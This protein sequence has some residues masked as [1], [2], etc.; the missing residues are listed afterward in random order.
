M[1]IIPIKE[2]EAIV[3]KSDTMVFCTCAETNQAQYLE[4]VKAW[5]AYVHE[6]VNADL[7]V[8][9]DGKLLSNNQRVDLG[10][11]T[12]VEFPMVAG[13][14]SI[15][16]FPG[17]KRSFAGA[18]LIS[19]HYKYFGHIEND[20]FVKDI[21]R[22]DKYL[23]TDNTVA[24][25]WCSNHNF[26]E[27][28]AAVIN[29]RELREELYQFYAEQLHQREKVNFED[30]VLPLLKHWTPLFG[31]S[32]R[33]EK[34][35]R[36][37]LDYDIVC[38]CDP[39]YYRA[40]TQHYT[41]PYDLV[42]NHSG[43]MGDLLYSLNYAKEYAESR[44]LDQFVLNLQLNQYDGRDIRLSR[45]TVEWL[46]PLLLNQPYIKD[47]TISEKVPEFCYNLDTF[48]NGSV[49]INAGDIRYWFYR[50][51]PN[52]LPKDFYSPML[53]AP[54][55][56]QYGDNIIISRTARHRNRDL[57]Y[58]KLEP[59]QDKILFVGTKQEHQDFCKEQFPCEYRP[60]KDAL[61]LATI[62][63]SAKLFI[64][65]QC[66]IFAIAEQLKVPRMLE[67]AENR[68]GS[69]PNV[70]PMGGRCCAML[71]SPGM[72]ISIG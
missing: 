21:K 52:F 14:Q 39:T 15:T 50:P 28:T 33:L 42:F 9:N 57:N 67:T 11:V 49:N 29:N 22:F 27:F 65:N 34:G 44:G 8:I 51:R 36:D 64:G 56:P 6:N 47:V 35:N 1:Q 20:C 3:P 59:L 23:H 45:E 18:L 17:W 37:T 10:D 32:I 7:Y 4:K 43:K 2:H 13:R 24:T 55:D 53:T 58:K 25:G 69:A 31:D 26:L 19:R 68:P 63:N 38:Q 66:G 61:E 12:F 70:L 40:L 30:Q 16:A 48:R 72:G 54:K 5:Y 60:V 41:Q 62:I 46:K 71:K